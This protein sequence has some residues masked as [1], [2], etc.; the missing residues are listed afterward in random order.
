MATYVLAYHGGGM[1]ETEAEQATVMAAW[2][3]WYGQIGAALVDGGNPIGKTKTISSSG[4]VSDGGGAN[5]IS[6][7]TIIKVD[8]IDQAV[9]CAKMCPILSAGGSVEV[10]ETMEVM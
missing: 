5:P 9:A 10:A 4:A 8:T 6:G 1:P 2:G 7:Y 3:A